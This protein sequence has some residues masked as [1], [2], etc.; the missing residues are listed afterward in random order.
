MWKKLISAFTGAPVE[1]IAD[2]FKEKQQLKHDLRKAKLAGRIKIVE[3]KAAAEAKRA[4]HVASWELAQIRNSGWKD[5][6]VLLTLSYPAWASFVPWL[7]DSV[8]E[9]FAILGTTPYWYMALLL[10]VYMAIYGIRWKFA[11]T[12]PIK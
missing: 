12:I 1:Q 4:E 5:E 10:A 3:A 6:F 11:E 9:G 2:Y 7:Q 8:A